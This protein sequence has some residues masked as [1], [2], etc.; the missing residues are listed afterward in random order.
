MDVPGI[1]FT[2]IARGYGLNATSVSTVG[3]FAAAFKSALASGKPTLI[4]V[5]TA[6]TRP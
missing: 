4:E 3:D 5:E 6:K 2:L 1:D